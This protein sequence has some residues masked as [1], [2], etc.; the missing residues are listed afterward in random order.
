MKKLASAFIALTLFTVVSTSRAVA[1]LSSVTY[2]GQAANVKSDK[3]VELKATATFVVSN[4]DLVITMSNI[5][6]NDSKNPSDILTGIFF[7]SKVPFNLTRGSVSVGTESS[8]VG[9]RLPLGFDDDVSGQWAYSGDLP[10]GSRKDPYG[11]YG[12]ASTKFSLL[13]KGDLFSDIK[14]PGTHPLS[15]AQFGL[16]T[17]Y[18][19]GLNDQGSIKNVGL[20]QNTIV[21]VL[22][23]LPAGF[24]T[25]DIASD[26]EN[27]RFEFGTSL[28]KGINIAG[29]MVQ[30]I[31]EPSTV[32]LVA[33]GLMGAIALT[34]KRPSSR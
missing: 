14:I 13:N 16:T 8:V 18:D 9:W 7:D 1:A 26:I 5:S 30:Q 22:D 28:K 19:N 31:P 10:A 29:E 21:I 6:T 11:Q 3:G 4:L 20:V 12:I 15:G 32:A 23:G 34:R 33:T 17:L 27:V 24:T 2:T 25:A